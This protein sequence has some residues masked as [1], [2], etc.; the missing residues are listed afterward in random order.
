MKP[1]WI[2]SVFVLGLLPCFT[3]NSNANHH[4]IGSAEHQYQILSA[5]PTDSKVTIRLTQ[6][7]KVIG[8]F[9]FLKDG[10]KNNTYFN[11]L[12]FESGMV[13]N[14]SNEFT[15]ELSLPIF[16]LIIDSIF[17]KKDDPEINQEIWSNPIPEINMDDFPELAYAVDYY[18]DIKDSALI[19]VLLEQI[20]NKIEVTEKDN[21][22]F[23]RGLLPYL[24][25]YAWL[26]P[27]REVTYN[28]LSKT[29]IENPALGS[30]KQNGIRK[31]LLNPRDSIS[32]DALKRLRSMMDTA[33]KNS[34]AILN[35][36]IQLDTIISEIDR[37]LENN[38]RHTSEKHTS[39][40]TLTKAIIFKILKKVLHAQSIQL[41]MMWIDQNQYMFFENEK[42]KYGV[43]D[44]EKNKDRYIAQLL[45]KVFE[46]YQGQQGLHVNWETDAKAQFDGITFKLK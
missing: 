32:P 40:F 2:F 9:Q 12:F 7:G 5:K 14:N 15:M 43:D 24:E 29:L 20:K 11:N 31:L 37:A 33:W 23:L 4:Y 1:N 36:K 45:R 3:S 13:E 22:E 16:H 44:F 8:E 46:Y 25:T 42:F 41:P 19:Y 26:E 38:L 10:F 21:L 39:E 28:A 30:K 27:L 6:S 17:F 35:E 18:F 34:Q